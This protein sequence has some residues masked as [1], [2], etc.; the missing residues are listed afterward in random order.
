M[1]P[2]A[3][4]IKVGCQSIIW[5]SDTIRTD[6]PRVI[7]EI[8]DCGYQ[9]VEIGAR[10]LDLKSPAR[11]KR[12]LSES[13]IKLVGLHTDKS[14]LGAEESRCGFKKGREILNSLVELE[15][16]YLII[17]GQPSRLEVKNLEQL[18]LYAERVGLKVCY[19]NHYQ[20]IHND[21]RGL[22]Q[23]CT[24]THPDLVNLALDLGWVHR[25]GKNAQ[26][27]IKEFM[28]RVELYHF[29]DVVGVLPLERNSLTGDLAA[30]VE[31][32]E[33]DLCW[34]SIVGLLKEQ[35]FSGWVVVEQDSTKKS[36]VVS[37]CQSRK[38]LKEVCSI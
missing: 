4:E 6:L 27:A 20:E 28:D 14:C 35:A 12:L 34:T 9:G 11:I 29:K 22:R 37:C 10:H 23:I 17:S 2:D 16:D 7:S 3:D 18:G 32:G 25:A 1:T 5:G 30:A 21:Y 15:G 8:A 26:E 36:P 38:Y 24:W 33:G 31:I 13:S 19:H